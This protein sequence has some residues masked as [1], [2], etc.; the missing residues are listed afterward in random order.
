[1]S[2]HTPGP[3]IVR[4]FKTMVG[5]C[6]KVGPEEIV[7]NP[8]GGICLY[9]DHTTL[10]PQAHEEIAANARLIAAA[11]ELLEAIERCI[12]HMNIYSYVAH[13]NGVDGARDFNV[14]LGLAKAA[15]AKAEG[16]A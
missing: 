9:D 14:S 10:N 16:R 2:K 4:T 3:W 6:H 7:K 1:M 5:I 8:Q 12:M 13:P 11:P 15:I